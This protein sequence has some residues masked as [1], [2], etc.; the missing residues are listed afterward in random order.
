MRTIIF[1]IAAFL[2]TAL[3]APAQ[4][5]DLIGPSGIGDLLD[6]PAPRGAAPARGAAPPARGA[7]PN[8]PP[9]D[10]L[11]RLRELLVQ[12]N[13]PLTKEQ[14]TGLNGL[15]NAEVP[16]MRQALQRKAMQIASLKRGA[17]P[18]GSGAAAASGT[19]G[20]PPTPPAGAA[21]AGQ[22]GP[23]P[24]AAMLA[25][26]TSE[27]IAPEIIRLNDQLLGKIAAAPTL[28]PPQQAVVKKIY[29]DQV[30]AHGGFEAIAMAME[31]ASVP[32]TAEQVTQIQPLFE[33]K[34]KLRLQLT[35]E[36]GGQPV[37]K[38]KLDQLDRDTLAKLLRLLTPA[39]RTALLQPKP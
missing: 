8:A 30:K 7:A 25:N 11:V 10:R 16:L 1:A 28:S 33:E 26:V 12:S 18:A 39:Q 23:N 35:K 32:F 22:R 38:T 6:I 36:A 31:D 20:A 24:M 15:L 19:P 27:D 3:P 5:V 37:D 29:K 34:E 4:E 21:P 17:P 2:L 13:A 14:E 9:V